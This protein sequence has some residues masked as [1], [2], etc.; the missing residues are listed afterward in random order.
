MVG[1]MEPVLGSVLMAQN[2]LGIL[3]LSL[4]LSVPPLLVLSLSLFLFHALALSPKITHLKK[5]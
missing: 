5:K 1:E 4:S 3:S 2:L